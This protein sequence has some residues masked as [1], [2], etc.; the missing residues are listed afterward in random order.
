MTPSAGGGAFGGLQQN[1]FHQR[2]GDIELDLDE[3][4]QLPNEQ[5]RDENRLSAQF[6]TR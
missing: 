6:G 2:A 3:S 4:R 5:P 1:I